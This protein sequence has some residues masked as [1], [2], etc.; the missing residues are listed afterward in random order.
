MKAIAM[1]FA[2]FAVATPISQA[3]ADEPAPVA[4]FSY[5][6]ATCHKRVKNMHS[7]IKHWSP[8][9]VSPPNYYM[10]KQMV[11]PFW[12][13]TGDMYYNG[14]PKGGLA[15]DKIVAAQWYQS[16]AME[17]VPT[18]QYKLGRMMLEGDGIP[19]NLEGGRA[20][21]TSAALEGSS[22]AARYLANAGLP[23]PQPINPASYTIAAR[24]AKAE[25]EAGQARD[26]AAIVGDLSRLVVNVASA[27]VA[28]SVAS[29]VAPVVKRAPTPIAAAPVYS[30]PAMRRP[31]FC[32]T[33]GTV[34]PSAVTDTAWVN[35]ST[36]CN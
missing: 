29:P 8:G 12:E 2:T 9:A 34:T 13:F 30:V 11:M 19:A 32:N 5:D 1:L 10:Y 16:A 36:F 18:A 22:E 21:M 31:V 3:N 15:A 23:I 33:Y 7:M 20:W 4:R 26:R 27:Y 14:C 24:Q 6:H 25:L 28:A 17:F 35:V